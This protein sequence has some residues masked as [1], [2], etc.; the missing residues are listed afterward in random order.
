MVNYNDR[1]YVVQYYTSA[2]EEAANTVLTVD[3]KLLGCF[4]YANQDGYMQFFNSPTVPAD[5]TAPTIASFYV[6]A[7]S[8][9]SL[10]VSQ[11]AGI[12]FPQ[13]LSFAFSST[14]PTKTK[15]LGPSIFITV[16]FSS[17]G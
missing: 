14:G 12:V 9:I 2:A 15:L 6:S 13:G 10:D 7:G 4:G 1:E 16:V 3:C 8:N 11:V 5:G 17:F